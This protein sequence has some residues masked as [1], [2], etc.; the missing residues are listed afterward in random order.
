[1]SHS[2][3]GVTGGGGDRGRVPPET[4]DDLLGKKGKGVTIEKRRK[5]GKGKVE[6]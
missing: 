5:I 2:I 3:S 4:S 1:M 6:N